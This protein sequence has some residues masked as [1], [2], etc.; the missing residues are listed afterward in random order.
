MSNVDVE[1]VQLEKITKCRKK[2][3]SRYRAISVQL[4]G[5]PIGGVLLYHNPVNRVSSVSVSV[6]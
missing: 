6:Q 3:L 1:E 4:K 5:C 2:E